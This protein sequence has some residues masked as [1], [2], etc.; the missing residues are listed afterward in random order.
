ME[1]LYP[2]GEYYLASVLYAIILSFNQTHGYSLA[3][4]A[5]DRDIL[6]PVP[7]KIDWNTIKNRKQLK[8][9]KSNAKEN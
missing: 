4:L 7:T 8:T 2:F 9:N 1:E 5:L 6:L 3:Q